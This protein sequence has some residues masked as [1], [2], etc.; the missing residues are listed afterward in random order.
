MADTPDSQAQT[1]RDSVL[2]TLIERGVPGLHHSLGKIMEEWLPALKYGNRMETMQEMKDHP[3]IGGPLLTMET[4]INKTPL[5]VTSADSSRSSAEQCAEEFD[6]ALYDMEHSFQD[7]WS[8][9]LSCLWAGNAPF[10]IQW[11]RRLGQDPGNDEQGNPL[12]TSKFKDGKIGLAKLAI[13]GQ[14]TIDRWEFLPNGNYCGFWQTDPNG[15]STSYIPISGCLHYRLR[16]FKN[17][18]EGNGLVRIAYEPYMFLKKYQ[19]L[20]AV[21]FERNAFGIPIF[22]VPLRFLMNGATADEKAFVDSLYAMGKGLRRDVQEVMVTP[23]PKDANGETGFGVDHFKGGGSERNMGLREAIRD[24][25]KDVATAMACGV[26]F[27]GMD[28]V[29]TTGAGT[30]HKDMLGM[31]LESVMDSMLETF[32]ST[33]PVKFARYNGY[34]PEDAPKLTRGRVIQPS[35]SEVAAFFK[36]MMDAGAVIPDMGLENYLRNLVGSPPK[37]LKGDPTVG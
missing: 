8:A 3:A 7:H 13:R 14:D 17:N 28:K 26:L 20:E 16:P 22:Y 27:L 9:A 25:Q 19:V 34:Q 29:G 23:P 32:N 12:P 30:V 15:Y 6:Q 36:P 35:P 5:S 18:P 2:P 21:G 33:I 31:V 37:D 10:W 11:K 4:L 24:L 1:V